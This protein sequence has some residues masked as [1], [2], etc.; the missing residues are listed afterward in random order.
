M[1]LIEEV[2]T[3]WLV[4]RI[5]ALGGGIMKTVWQEL[6]LTFYSFIDGNILIAF[7]SLNMFE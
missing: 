1:K 7:P 6:E 3:E 2:S 4:L 5:L